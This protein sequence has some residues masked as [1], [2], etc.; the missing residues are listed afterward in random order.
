MLFHSMEQQRKGELINANEE[1]ILDNNYF[2]KEALID[3]EMCSVT[4]KY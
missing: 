1:K 4:K 3:F 2:Y